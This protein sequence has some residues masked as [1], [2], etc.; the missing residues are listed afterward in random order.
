M[1]DVLPY[2]PSFLD[3]DHLCSEPSLSV[4]ENEVQGKAAGDQNNEELE[5][6]ADC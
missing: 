3:F 1:S 4:P 6:T 2:G 5:G